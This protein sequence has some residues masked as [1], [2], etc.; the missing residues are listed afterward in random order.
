MMSLIPFERELLNT[1]WN[2]RMP[3]AYS[4]G[5]ECFKLRVD[6]EDMGDFFEMTADL[7]GF[8]K[9]EVK[10]ELN[11]DQLMISADKNEEKEVKEKN[12]VYK[13]R[14]SG[15]YRR[16]F[17]ISGIDKEGIEG[18]FADG[19]LKLVL[20]KVEEEKEMHRTLE[21]KD[22]HTKDEMVENA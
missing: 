11:G 17:D 1:F 21:L 12:Y 16:S 20:P 19:V 13:E 9:D 7:P 15:S 5:N 18:S 8:S 6:V 4:K 10:I 2:R 3:T 14:R 22:T